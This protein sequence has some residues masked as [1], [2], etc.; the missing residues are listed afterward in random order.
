[1]PEVGNGDLVERGVIFK[2]FGERH[3]KNIT[4]L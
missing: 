2:W 1:L 3:E 4:D